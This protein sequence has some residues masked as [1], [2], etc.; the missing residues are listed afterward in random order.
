[1]W[2]NIP[3]CNCS[4]AD[5][6]KDIGFQVHSR[7]QSRKL[8]YRPTDGRQLGD[9][10]LRDREGRDADTSVDDLQVDVFNHLYVKFFFKRQSAIDKGRATRLAKRPRP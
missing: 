5:H 2:A 4:L 6:L 7:G 3:K 9:I 8:V 1:L 10:M